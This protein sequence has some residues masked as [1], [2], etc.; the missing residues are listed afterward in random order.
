MIAHFCQQYSEEYWLL[1]RGVPTA[2]EMNKILTPKTGRLSAQADDYICKLIGDIFN[3]DYLAEKLN[4]EHATEAMR[5]GSEREAEARK[6]YSFVHGVDVQQVGFCTT[7]DGRFGCSPDGLIGDDGLLELKNPSHAVQA[8]YLIDGG[9]PDEYRVQVHGQLAVT[10]RKW[11][12]FR[13]YCPP[14]PE[15]LVRVEPDK[16]T[17]LLE[18]ALNQF[19]DKYQS[20]LARFTVKEQAA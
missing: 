6:H 20:L 7:D 1:R 2:S 13:S 4:D 18:E 11:L 17:L 3:P 8:R 15:L 9:L 14:L 10:G 16:F 12:H 5:R 19:W